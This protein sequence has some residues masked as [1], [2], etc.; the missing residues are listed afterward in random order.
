MTAWVGH[1]GRG[2]APKST[3]LS[4]ERTFIGVDVR[5]YARTDGRL[6]RK[7]SREGGGVR[8]TGFIMVPQGWPGGM[9]GKRMNRDGVA[10]L[11]E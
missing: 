1:R 2:V 5:A 4:R 6:G 7:S 10:M 9:R 8:Q 3:L 11:R